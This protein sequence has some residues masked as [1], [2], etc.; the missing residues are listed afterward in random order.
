MPT[1]V[2]LVAVPGGYQYV[3]TFHLLACELQCRMMYQA[4]Q[5]RAKVVVVSVGVDE[6]AGKSMARMDMGC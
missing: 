2:P 6:T 5:F 3:D 1:N 4:E